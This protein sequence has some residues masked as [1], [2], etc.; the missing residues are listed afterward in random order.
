MR[1]ADT[2]ELAR[3]Y[4]A[5]QMPPN[6]RILTGDPLVYA[7]PLDRN[8]TSITRARSIRRTGFVVLGLVAVPRA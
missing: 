2:R 7:V 1:A 3:S 5:E 8:E 4:I 6:T